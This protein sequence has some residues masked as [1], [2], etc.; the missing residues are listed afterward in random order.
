MGDS[1][2][3][4]DLLENKRRAV[5]PNFAEDVYG[6]KK[7]TQS[8]EVEY[9]ESSLAQRRSAL[10]VKLKQLKDSNGTTTADVPVNRAESVDMISF[11]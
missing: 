1:S 8:D 3:E 11:L 7:L 10:L 4:R 2:A 6:D 9:S 5:R